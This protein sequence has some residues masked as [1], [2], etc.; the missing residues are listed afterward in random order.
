[1]LSL[2]KGLLQ[3]TLDCMELKKLLPETKGPGGG[4]QGI[5][6]PLPVA[7]GKLANP[8]PLTQELEEQD[9]HLVLKAEGTAPCIPTQGS[10]ASCP[11]APTLLPQT[12]GLGRTLRAE[13]WAQ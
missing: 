6:F 13:G 9:E 4:N 5:G 7:T 12:L 3:T 10:P 11:R 8:H 1:M 2:S